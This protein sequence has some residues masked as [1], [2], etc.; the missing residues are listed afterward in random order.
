MTQTEK[1]LIYLKTKG[2]TGATA[3][4]LTDLFIPQYGWCIKWLRGRGHV[5]DARQ[6]REQN[7]KLRWRFF[8]RGQ[9]Q[10][11]MKTPTEH[12]HEHDGHGNIRFTMA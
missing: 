5:I 4:E 1:V 6:G 7:G 12:N 11:K 10:S 2:M 9:N 3:K 8:Y